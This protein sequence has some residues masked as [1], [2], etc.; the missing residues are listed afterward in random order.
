[1]MTKA[2]NEANRIMDHARDDKPG[3]KKLVKGV[4]GMRACR[5]IILQKK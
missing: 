2:M 5:L 3:K 4:F 1:M